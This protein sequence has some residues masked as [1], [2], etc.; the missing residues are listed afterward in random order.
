[1]NHFYVRSLDFGLKSLN[2]QKFEFLNLKHPFI[3]TKRAYLTP[4]KVEPLYELFWDAGKIVHENEDSL[5]EI[6][7]RVL[8]QLKLLREDHKRHLNPTPYKVRLKIQ[9][10]N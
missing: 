6:R 5:E 1:M 8:L 3:A 4:S 9:I 10:K 2:Y 7:N